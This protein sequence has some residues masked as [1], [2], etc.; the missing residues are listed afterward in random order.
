MTPTNLQKGVVTLDS[1]AAA[2]AADK[3]G[4]DGASQENGIDNNLKKNVITIKFK[5]DDISA[6]LVKPQ[7]TLEERRKSLLDHHWAVPSKERF[8]LALFTWEIIIFNFYF[9]FTQPFIRRGRNGRR[10]RCCAGH[11]FVADFCRCG[12]RKSINQTKL[13]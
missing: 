9:S 7:S 10:C 11:Q 8:V 12:G 6:S 1:V 2:T 4:A 3:T 13:S 5:F